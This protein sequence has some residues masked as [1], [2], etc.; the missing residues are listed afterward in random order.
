MPLNL[1]VLDPLLQRVPGGGLADRGNQRQGVQRPIKQIHTALEVAIGRKD[2]TWQVFDEGHRIVLVLV[3]RAS[4]VYSSVLLS[5]FT[6]HAASDS[7]HT[8]PD[9]MQT[10]L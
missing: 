7:V 1:A 2:D 5:V 4:E 9:T 10:C 8:P 6:Q 3:F